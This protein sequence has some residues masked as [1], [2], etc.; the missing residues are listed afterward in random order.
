MIKT[1]EEC[2]KGCDESPQD[3]EATYVQVAQLVTFA[4]P[5]FHR[6]KGGQER[7]RAAESNFDVESILLGLQLLHCSGMVEKFNAP[8]VLFQPTVAPG[9]LNGRKIA[10]WRF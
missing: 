2:M 4:G 1:N 3:K 7:T 10:M 8:N 5:V 6:V 9:H